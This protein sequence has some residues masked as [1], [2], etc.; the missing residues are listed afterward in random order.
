MDPQQ[1]DLARLRTEYA[2]R[3]RRLAGSDIYSP[4]NKSTLFIHQQRQ[5]AIVSLLK[6]HGFGSLDRKHILELGCGCGGVLQ[7]LLSLG[8][9]PACLHGTD[10]LPDRVK[11]AHD[12]LPHLPLTVSDGRHLPY[13][14]ASFDLVLQ[15]T[16]FSS[17]L[18]DPLKTSL[19]SE[20]LRVLL[21]GGLILWY[22]FWLNPTNPQTRG[23][24][25]AEIKTLFPGCTFD[26][27]KITLA[28]PLARRL[29]PLSWLLS[30][31]LEKLTILNT[32]YL[33]AIR[34]IH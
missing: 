11:D 5:R 13:P 24:R 32:H 23:I 6:K 12:R 17:V 3:Q 19:A 18:D 4:F 21:P 10:L 14:S 33:V 1:T 2:D 25:P 22:D 29:V 34:K 7:E 26:F 9:Q 28:P 15:F 20:M 31:L 30:A 27:H 16:V 8:A